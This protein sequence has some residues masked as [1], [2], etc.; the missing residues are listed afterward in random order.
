[1]IFDTA[2]IPYMG[3]RSFSRIRPQ[4]TLELQACLF[5]DESYTWQVIAQLCPVTFTAN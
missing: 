2:G 5:Q 3:Y 1:M 4:Q